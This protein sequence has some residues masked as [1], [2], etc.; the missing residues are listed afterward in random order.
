MRVRMNLRQCVWVLAVALSAGITGGTVRAAASPSSQDQGHDQD[1][2]HEHH[3]PLQ[4]SR[5]ALAPGLHKN[6]PKRLATAIVGP[7]GLDCLSSR[8]AGPRPLLR[9]RTFSG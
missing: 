1:T 3:D 6:L 9:E 5:P 4:N 2:D 8:P 7:T